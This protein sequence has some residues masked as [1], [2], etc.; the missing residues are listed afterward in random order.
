[1]WQ[2]WLQRGPHQG[3]VWVLGCVPL[4]LLALVLWLP[5][6]PAWAL[7]QAGAAS[8]NTL[9]AVPP[10]AHRVTDQTDTLSP[11][12]AQ[13]LETQL[14][15]IEQSLGSQIVVLMVPSTQPE[16]IA[17][18]AFR[19]A[20]QWKVGRKGVGDGVL[21]LVAKNDRMVR[22]EVAKSLEGAIPDLAAR[23]IIDRAITPAF[24]AGDFTGGLRAGVE[25]LAARIGAENLPPGQGDAHG[26]TRSA[27]A[28]DTWQQLSLLLFMGAPVLG[29]VLSSILG[30]K[31]GAF[32]S[33]LALGALG[34]FWTG[35]AWLAALAG[36][37]AMVLVGV[38]GVGTRRTSGTYPGWGGGGWGGGPGRGSGG[39]WSGGGGFSSGGGGNFGGGGASGKW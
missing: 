14:A 10:L 21:V 16:D 29:S 15:Q 27:S 28:E 33:G 30:R 19:V 12:D 18:F 6:P 7:G 1:M 38:L 26:G 31:L 24:K 11:A 35:S 25:Q 4:A 36:L 22:I 3:W 20:D 34:W 5:S 13:A 23:Q 2:R 8:A 32:A 39:G 9:V 17:S 37:L